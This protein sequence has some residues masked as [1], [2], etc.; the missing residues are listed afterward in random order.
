M[1]SRAAVAAGIAFVCACHSS[2][3]RTDAGNA[4]D[5]GGPATSGPIEADFPHVPLL[6]KLRNVIAVTDGDRVSVTFEPVDGAADY[7]I[8]PLPDATNV[9]V[10]GTGFVTVANQTYRCAGDREAPSAPLDTAD[11]AGSWVATRVAFEVAGFSRTAADATLGHVFVEPGAGRLPV[12][13]AGDDAPSADNE[14]S[15]ASGN[16]GATRVKTYT[17][18]KAAYDQLVAQGFRDDGVAFYAPETGLAVM[19]SKEGTSTLYYSSAA[20]IAARAADEPAEAFRVL[21]APADGTVPLKRVFY[22]GFCGDSHDE[23]VAGESRFSRAASQGDQPIFETQWSGLTGK[24]I[25]VVEALQTGCPFQGHLVPKHKDASGNAQAFLTLDEIRKASPTGEVF[26]NGQHDV[27]GRPRAIARSFVEASPA[28][29]PAADFTAG[30]DGAPETFTVK[31]TRSDCGGIAASLSSQS[32][33]AQFY[34]TEAAGSPGQVG[35]YSLGQMLGEFWVSF[36]DAGSLTNGKFRMT[37]RQKATFSPSSYLHATMMVD[38]VSTKRRY[39]QMLVSDVPSPV[40]ENLTAGRT[41]ILQAFDG[42]PSRLEIQVCDHKTWDVNDQCPRYD[43]ERAPGTRKW[44]GH[45]PLAERSGVGRLTRVDL[46]ASTSKALVFLDGKPY[47]CVN[48]A[49]A[50]AAGPVSVT[51]GDVLYHSGIDEYVTSDGSQSGTEM[52]FHWRHQ[53]TETHR[54][55]DNL[56]FSSNQAEP[57]WD[58]VRFP[59]ATVASLDL[60]P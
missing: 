21:S 28:P 50:P 51:F 49:N 26:L 39:P 37:A 34:C 17:T 30:F 1:S 33:D 4:P 23:L 2:T 46:W 25:L 16:W 19:T 31:S 47:G 6:P 8:Y 54:Q 42:W 60:A 9:S 32:F 55:L 48:L 27:A 24:T 11:H 40:Q 12:Y 45:E 14:C 22:E 7:R 29:R 5:A 20:E 35:M 38:L 44:F 52:S 57:R 3:S 13:A 10:D 41:L 18:S 43:L 15:N 59:C 58:P 36:A 56:Q 53:L